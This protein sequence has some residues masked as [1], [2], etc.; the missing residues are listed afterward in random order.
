MLQGFNICIIGSG[1]DIHFA[2]G[3]RWLVEAEGCRL[4]F[5]A[6][7]RSSQT[8][9]LLVNPFSLVHRLSCACCAVNADIVQ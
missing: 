8:R 9:L 3:F 2:A 1:S 5:L 4:Y 7:P 6:I